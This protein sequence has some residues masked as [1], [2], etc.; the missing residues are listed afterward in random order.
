M[1]KAGGGEVVAGLVG[2]GLGAVVEAVKAYGPDRILLADDPRLRGFSAQAYSKVAAKMLEGL[3]DPKAVLAP[4]TAMGRELL[5]RLAAEVGGTVAPDATELSPREG[6]G[7]VVSRPIFGGRASVQ[8]DLPALPCVSLRPNAFAAE[9]RP[10][11]SPKVENVAIPELPAPALALKVEKTV[12]SRGDTP[13]LTE[14][15][16]IISGGRGLKGPENFVLIENLAKVLGA[17]VG[18]SRAVVDAGW[19]PASEQVGQTGKVVSPNL[20]VACGIS[21][22]IQHLVGMSSSRCI[23][24][25][26]KDPAAPIFKVANYG[27][28][29]D[30]LTILPALTSTIA[31]S[32]GVPV[33]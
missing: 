15:P 17:G 30:A 21:G 12:V 16:I 33:P 1:S 25:I 20:Y 9:P 11:S 6:G 31:K 3:A 4:A 8:V 24:A 29:G 2:A 7:L 23:V 28:V 10:G 18:A 22:A 32:R 27:V 14:A 5:P 19:R 26:N 13:E